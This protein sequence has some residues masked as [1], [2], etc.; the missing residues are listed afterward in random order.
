[1]GIKQ[2]I[3]LVGMTILLTSC[4]TDKYGDPFYGWRKPSATTELGAQYLLGR[5]VP[6]DDKRA[7]YYFSQAAA[8]GDPLAQNELG[9]MYAAGK[10]TA[11]DYNKSF[12]FYHQAAMQGL[13]SAQYN[14]GLLYMHGLGTQKN[15]AQGLEWIK[16]AADNGFEPARV[17]LNR[18]A[19]PAS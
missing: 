16:K 14:L 17:A 3:V 18:S 8:K 4:A 13:A 11:R 10:G 7:F 12:I 1:M 15:T 9:Y 2:Q 5:G 19:K 6:K